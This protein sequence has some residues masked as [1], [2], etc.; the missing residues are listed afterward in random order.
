MI[1]AGS[2]MVLSSPLSATDGENH[3]V[4]LVINFDDHSPNPLYSG[5]KHLTASDFRIF[6]T[7][8]AI[9]S[10]RILPA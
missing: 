10:H 3:C 4:N 9:K 5:N 2:L 6:A 1:V 8:I 7:S